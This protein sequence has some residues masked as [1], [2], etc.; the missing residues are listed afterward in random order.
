MGSIFKRAAREIGKVG[1]AVVALAVVGVGAAVFQSLPSA[2]EPVATD[3]GWGGESL[4]A[5]A[6][7]QSAFSIIGV[8]NACGL[9]ASSCFKCHNGTRAAAPN[10]DA[11]AA[12]WHAE[13]R[14]VNNSCAGCHNGNPR[15]IRKEMAHNKLI[16][17]PQNHPTE[18]CAGCHAED[19]G[20][21]VARYVSVMGGGN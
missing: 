2:L 17:K 13:H 11:A 7:G 15:I 14:S 4:A 1:V 9:G 18:S 5:I 3:N 8:A 19:A 10:E 12:P 16:G 21:K 6:E 20:E